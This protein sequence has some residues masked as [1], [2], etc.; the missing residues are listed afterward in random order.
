[1]LLVA[2]AFLDWLEVLGYLPFGWDRHS[3]C[4]HDSVGPLKTGRGKA[5]LLLLLLD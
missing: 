1:M 5:L 2:L 4:R 3:T